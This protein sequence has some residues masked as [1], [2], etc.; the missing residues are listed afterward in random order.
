VDQIIII[1]LGGKRKQVRI[2]LQNREWAILKNKNIVVLKPEDSRRLVEYHRERPIEGGLWK[3]VCGNCKHPTSHA[4]G[5][6][7]KVESASPSAAALNFTP[8]P[9]HDAPAVVQSQAASSA[10]L[11]PVENKSSSILQP[12]VLNATAELAEVAPVEANYVVDGP[13]QVEGNKTTALEGAN[14]ANVDDEN[15][16]DED[17]GNPLLNE[18]ND[19]AMKAI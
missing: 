6:N 17:T 12:V 19:Y 18:I 2:R 4:A 16:D 1:I 9:I 11:F 5:C 15:E 3:L 8:G 7:G 13:Q 14:T 10:V